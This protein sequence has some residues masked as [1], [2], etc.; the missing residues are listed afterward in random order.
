M[1]RNELNAFIQEHV[2][3]TDFTGGVSDTEITKV[4]NELNVV[5][6]RSYKWFLKNYGS[7]GLFGVDILGCGKSAIPSVVSNTERLR[8]LGLPSE[9]I[10]IEDCDEFFYCLD[11]GNLLDGECSI[12]SWDRVAGFSGKRAN[13]FY[14]F[15]SERLSEAKENWDE[16]F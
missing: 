10:V 8:N 4:E 2:D 1:E 7:G 12:I 14:D 16:D 15:L 3:D 5:F 13:G 9:Y 6:P 11:T